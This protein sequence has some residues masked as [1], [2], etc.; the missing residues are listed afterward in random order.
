MSAL[1][2]TSDRDLRKLSIASFP[3]RRPAMSIAFLNR[4]SQI[5]RRA[6]YIGL[7]SVVVISGLLGAAA[8]FIGK[9]K[10]SAQAIASSVDRTPELLE[11]EWHLPVAATFNRQL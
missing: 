5:G 1:Q 11:R 7:V 2:F 10:V 3:K 6:I 4:T 9:A 8:L